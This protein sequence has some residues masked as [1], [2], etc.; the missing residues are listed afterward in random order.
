MAT[1]QIVNSACLLTPTV[2]LLHVSPIPDAPKKKLLKTVVLVG[3]N[4]TC[5]HQWINTAILL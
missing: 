1:S 2:A 5:S 3:Y 4:L